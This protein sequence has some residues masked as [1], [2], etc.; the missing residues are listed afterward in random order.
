MN[1]KDSK[2][3]DIETQRSNFPILADVLKGDA[4]L[5]FFTKLFFYLINKKEFFVAPHHVEICKKLNE[6]LL[7]KHKTNNLIINIPPRHSKSELAVV[8][9]IAYAY[10]LNP[11]CE[12]MHLSSSEELINRN[13]THIRNILESEI[14]KLMF[15]DVKLTNNAKGSITTTKNGILYAAPFFGQITGFGCG[16]LKSD[17]FA[18]AM[19]IDDPIKTQDAMSDIKRDRINFT[20]TNTLE[21][22]KNDENTPVIVIMQRVHPDDFCG[23]LIKNE[24]TVEEGGKWDIVSMP[25]ILDEGTDNERALWELRKPLKSLK[26]LREKNSWVFET[27]YQQ[28]PKPLEGL[29]Y[30]K[31]FKTYEVIPATRYRLRKNYTDTADT[32]DN[33]LCS[34]N[35]IETEI[36]NYITD[37]LY[38][39]KPMDYT[40]QKTA[41]M[42]TREQ[43]SHAVIESNNGGRG[44]ARNVE[45][46]CR[47]MGN[48]IT[49][50]SWFNQNQNKQVRIFTRSAEAQNLTFFPSGWEKLYPPF[51]NHLTSYMKSGKNKF[52]DAPDAL[53]GTIEYRVKST[54]GGKAYT[55]K[56]K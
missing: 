27:Q 34:I 22:R 16:E 20:W 21:S 12:F 8:S 2:F 29:L 41:E 10:A 28:N 38:T 50:F 56:L 14:Y 5:L 13:V 23:Y 44:F 54:T 6:I 43:I 30:E 11:A 46:Q 53:T 19:I 7:C 25:A 3:I 55:A 52:D 9:F 26:K 17:K 45:Q 48:N 33:Y 47:I 42:I 51:Y 49:Q 36:G 31:P 32:G 1:A 15:P 24:G 37:I 4:K 40:E 35:Y 39:Q 18:G